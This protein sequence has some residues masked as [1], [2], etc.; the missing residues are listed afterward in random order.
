MAK[1][2]TKFDIGDIVSTVQRLSP[3]LGTKQPRA[4][5]KNR[6][7]SEITVTSDDAGASVYYVVDGAPHQ[8]FLP[9]WSEY[10][11]REAFFCGCGTELSDEDYKRD[12]RDYNGGLCCED[13][14]DQ[15]V[16]TVIGNAQAEEAYAQMLEEQPG[17]PTVGTEEF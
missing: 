8:D 15:M 12:V 9:G 6:K 4:G 5:F 11:L 3:H 13:C 16:E 14:A 2:T 17:A 10:E 1:F 7:V